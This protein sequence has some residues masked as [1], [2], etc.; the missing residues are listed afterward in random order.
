[1]WQ[2]ALGDILLVEKEIA[3]VKDKFAVAVMRGSTVVGHTPY[4]TA[5]AVSHFL[6]RSTNKAKV[7]VTG[8]AINRG[9]EYGIQII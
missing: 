1:M 4:N 8:A 2:P 5:P 7:E 6:K 9:T 3:N